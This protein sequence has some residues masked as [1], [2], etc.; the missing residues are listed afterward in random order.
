MASGRRPRLPP[1]RTKVLPRRPVFCDATQT[2][3][4]P[5]SDDHSWD[6]GVV[7]KIATTEADGVKTYT[8]TVCQATKTE[9]IPAFW[10]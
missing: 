7:T 9:A 8:C 10:V 4:L 1:A 6:D 3:S 5:K 2:K